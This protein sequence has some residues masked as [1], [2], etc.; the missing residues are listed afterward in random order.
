MRMRRLFRVLL[1][2]LPLLAAACGDSTGPG[3]PDL[4]TVEFAPALGV[5]IATMQKQEGVYFRDIKVGES[6]L[7]AGT[8]RSLQVRYR[9]YLANGAEFQNNLAPKPTF[10]LVL[11]QR[12]VIAGWERGIPGMKVGGKRLL[13]IPPSLGYG[14]RPNGPIPANSVLVFEVEVVSMS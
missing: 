5:D 4:N 12:S 2:A 6:E 8:G 11:G 1:C 13:V 14:D 9:G 7:T 3:D 10:G